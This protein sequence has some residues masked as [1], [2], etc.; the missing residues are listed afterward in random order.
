M[1]FFNRLVRVIPAGQYAVFATVM[2]G[3]AMTA[4]AFIKLAHHG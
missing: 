4:Y 2:V 1:G 3:V